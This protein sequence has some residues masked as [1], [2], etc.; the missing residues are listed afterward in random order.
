MELKRGKRIAHWCSS[1]GFDIETEFYLNLIIGG[2]VLK[3]VIC[4]FD[5]ELL[6]TSMCS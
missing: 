5:D 1:E 2:R 3:K 4:R 6:V